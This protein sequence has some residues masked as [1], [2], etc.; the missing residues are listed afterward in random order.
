MTKVF[1]FTHRQNFFFM[2]NAVST[3]VVTVHVLMC[4]FFLNMQ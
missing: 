3:A 1:F 4:N 2:L